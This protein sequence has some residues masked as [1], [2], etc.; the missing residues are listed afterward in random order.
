MIL[1]ND[2]QNKK[3]NSNSFITMLKLISDAILERFENTENLNKDFS[4]TRIANE[5]L[6][7]SER[8]VS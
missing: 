5:I 1:M 7:K 6:N 3:I 4:Q 2:Y 8:L